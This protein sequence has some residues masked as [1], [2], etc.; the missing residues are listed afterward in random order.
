MDSVHLTPIAT[1]FST[2]RLADMAC[3]PGAIACRVAGWESVSF[4]ELNES[5]MHEKLTASAATTSAASLM[6]KSSSMSKHAR[7]SRSPS[8]RRKATASP[9]KRR[10]SPR[11]AG[12]GASP[13]RR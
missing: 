5:N 10:P 13:T 6:R 9:T 3:S 8:P 12:M 2:Y 11:R 7:K 1:I 4:F